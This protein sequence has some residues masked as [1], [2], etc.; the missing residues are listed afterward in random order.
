MQFLNTPF[1]VIIDDDYLIPHNEAMYGT[2][3]RLD[4]LSI[5][6][7]KM[8]FGILLPPVEVDV[9]N[10]FVFRLDL[11]H[12]LKALKL[13]V[14][15]AQLCLMLDYIINR[16]TCCSTVHSDMIPLVLCYISVNTTA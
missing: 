13:K 10:T 16:S 8:G 11:S 7:N 3:H 9:R 5:L 14:C 2:M 4:F 1:K 15:A 12:H 6:A